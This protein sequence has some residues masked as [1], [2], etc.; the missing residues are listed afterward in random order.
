MPAAEVLTKIVRLHN[1]HHKGVRKEHGCTFPHALKLYSVALE[2]DPMDISFCAQAKQVP[3]HHI[4]F[5]H[6]QRGQVRE[7]KPI[8]S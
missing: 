1:C 3:G 4:T 2:R 5:A 8:N 6:V 7:Q